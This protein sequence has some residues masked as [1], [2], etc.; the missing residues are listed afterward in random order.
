M[1]S[2][3]ES[4]SMSWTNDRS[5]RNNSLLL[6]VSVVLIATAGGFLYWSRGTAPGT[7]QNQP[8]Q[9]ANPPVQSAFL[10]EPVEV[11]LYFP[12][13]GML[14]S[15]LVTVKRQP[16]D[17]AEAREALATMFLDQ[18][19]AQAPVLKDVKLRAFYLDAQG[20][21]YVDLTPGQGQPIRASAWDEQLAIYSMVN[22]LT[23]NFNVIRQVAFLVDGREAQTLAGHMDLS[24]KYGK[25]QDL[26][27]P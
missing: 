13:D 10:N 19:A 6:I 11:T 8:G 20:T 27:K 14:V 26:V 18:R 23:Q 15:S 5:I 9:N 16:D 24:R 1:P 17:L 22:T 4:S 21:A 25:R 3:E 2:R 7:V 12:R